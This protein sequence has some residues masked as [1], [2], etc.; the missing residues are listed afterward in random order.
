MHY[1]ENSGGLKH[2]GLFSL[3][4]S[5]IHALG[6]DHHHHPFIQPNIP[7]TPIF[8]PVVVL[9]TDTPTPLM[10]KY[11]V[12]LQHTLS[13]SS[14][15]TQNTNSVTQSKIHAKRLHTR[16]ERPDMQGA[17]ICRLASKSGGI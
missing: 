4:H 5:S 2:V 10:R 3:N 9:H 17:R 15:E 12:K 7:P 1:Y 11:D 8:L 16:P 14:H 13:W 6:E